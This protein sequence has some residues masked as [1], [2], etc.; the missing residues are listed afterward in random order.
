MRPLVAATVFASVVVTSAGAAPVAAAGAQQVGA[1]PC[2]ADTTVLGASGSR[3]DLGGLTDHLFVFTDGSEKANW[4]AASPGYVGDVAVNGVIADES[5]SGHMVY[6]GTIYTNAGSL[7]GWQS[8]IDDNPGRAT[9]AFNETAR[10]TQLQADLNAAFAQINA[11]TPTGGFAS[12][13]SS[14]LDGAN[15]ENGVAETIVINVTSDLSFSNYVNIRGDE[16]DLIVMRWDTDGNPNNGYQG[17]VK[18]SSGGAIVPQG[19]LTP[20]NFV[21]VAGDLNSSGGGTTPPPPYPQGPIDGDPAA[22]TF[23]SGG[24]FT[25]YWLTTGDPADRKTGSFSNGNFVGGWYSSTTEFSMTSGTSGLHVCPPNVIVPTYVCVSGTATGQTTATLVGRTTDPSVTQARF[26]LAGGPGT[27]ANDTTFVAPDRTFESNAT[28]LTANTNYTFKV[29]FL[30]NNGTVVGTSNNNCPFTTQAIPPTYVCVSGTATGQ[31]TATL[32]GRTTDPA[33]TQA[34]FV[35]AGGPGTAPNDTTFVAPDR[36][37]ESN[38]TGLTANTNYT[39]KVEFLNNNGTVV[40][41]S[42]NNCPFT[43]QPIAPTYI[44]VSGTATGQTTATLVGRTTDPAATQARFVLAGGPG[45][46]P[47]DTTFVAPDRTFESNATGL[48]ANTNYTFK[49]EF[50]NNNGTVVG[51]SNN[52][53]PF[54][55]QPIAPTYICVSGTATGQT[56]ATLVGRTTDPA[57][58]QARFVLAGGPGTVANDTTFVAPDRT[59]ESNATG[60]TVNT[61]YTFRVEF[62][63]NAGGVIGT[64]AAGGCPFTTQPIAPTYICVSGTATGQTTAT[65]VGRTNDPAATQARFVLAGGPGTAPNDTTFVAPDRTF[66]SNATGLTANTAYTFRVEFLNNAGTALGTSNNSCPFTTQPIA[67]TY[68]CVSAGNVTQNAATLRGETSNANVTSAV[69]TLTPVGGTI[70]TT[71]IANGGAGKLL[72]APATGLSAN[73]TYTYSISFRNAADNQVGTAIGTPECQFATP[74]VPPTYVCVSATGVTQTSAVL[75]G[76]TSDA[77]VASATFTLSPAGGTVANS[78]IAPGGAGKILSAVA[79]GLTP[80]VTYTYT[81]EFFNAAGVEVGTS[82]SGP[83]CSFPTSVANP[84]IRIIKYVN[85]DDANTAPGV[86]VTGS[87]MSFEMVVTNI[88]D[89]A[90]TDVTVTD[91]VLPASA[92]SCNGPG[93]SNVRAGTVA[94]GGTFTCTATLPA[95]APGTTH[96][97]LATVVGTTPNNTT[98][99]DDDPANA[100]V[101]PATQGTPGIL[102][103]KKVNGFDANDVPGVT[104]AV[105]S[106]LN[107]TYEVYNT[108][109]VVLSNVKV[110]DQVL[111]GGTSNVVVTCPATVLPVSSVPMICTGSAPAPASGQYT[112]VGTVVGTPPAGPPITDDDPANAFVATPGIEIIKYVNGADANDA[113]GLPVQAGDAVTW[114]YQVTNTGNVDLINVTVTDNKGVTVDCGG[115]NV[116]AL[117]RVKEQKVCTGSGVAILG[118][119]TNTGIAVGT[120]NPPLLPGQPPIPTPPVTDQDDANYIGNPIAVVLPPAAEIPAGELPATG[121]DSNGMLALA[122]G[123]LLV[124]GLLF[125]GARRRR[126]A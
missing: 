101:P 34:R 89:V 76:E 119:Y 62:L 116:I 118:Q 80:G 115:S 70:G 69:F 111:V 126:T 96:S 33:A 78:T 112:N 2:V 90:L 109:N 44:C 23:N 12:R 110:T 37:F 28:G 27:V 3:V 20:G 25:G 73:T 120:P 107:F 67:P 35:L 50:L 24:Y 114:T 32:V 57:A 18:L 113:P 54:T 51:T 43:T 15:F 65:L 79:T 19:G 9:A 85:T 72:S 121:S 95:P 99:T 60:L 91:N 36:T 123:L 40:G 14:S 53:C 29:E 117:L 68:V 63:S 97:N 55:T 102:I 31:T 49:V 47:N 71:V 92:I 105:G 103:I 59:F 104:V 41:T 77:T 100:H 64:S 74:P 75:K 108:G 38:A 7:D 106:T 88:G 46:A 1:G 83:A 22:S 13:S 42:N 125:A 98:V 52:N 66:E 17:E 45:T 124:G 6:R 93:T 4:Q 82:L 58:T 122:A 48:T 10:L 8:I 86:L 56:T 81:I 39:F 87:T 30:N 16:S 5:S 94:P 21:H 61:A 11:L 84:A 26:V